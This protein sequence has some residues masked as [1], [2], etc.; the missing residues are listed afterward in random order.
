MS[1][2]IGGLNARR[3]VVIGLAAVLIALGALLALTLGNPAGAQ[4]ID[5]GESVVAQAW[6]DEE[7]LTK[8]TVEGVASRSV[9]YDGA[10]GRFTVSA[11]R[12]TVQE[13]ALAGNRVVKAITDAVNESCTE[14]EPED[15]DHTAEPT[16]IS[17]NGLQHTSFWIGERHDWT[18]QGR[19]SLGFEYQRGFRIAL[20]GTGF[21]GGLVGLVLGAGGSDVSFEGLDLTSSRRAEVQRLA[22]LDAIDDAQ[23]TA[24]SIAGH[25]GY[26]IVRVVE[27]SPIGSLSASRVTEEAAEAAFAD[28]GYEPTPVFGGSD[29]V[30]E[31]VRMVFELRPLAGD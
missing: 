24:D 7:L 1:D 13:A 14:S 21:S 6:T 17:P 5:S 28:D 22:L 12:P 27:V 18:E 25:M 3:Y 2:S 29:T 16:C 9:S 31:R 20:R 19:V 11:L 23:A 8:L 30:T 26:E 10:V 4:E 15:A